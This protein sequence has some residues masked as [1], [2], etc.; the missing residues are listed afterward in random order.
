M[1]TKEVGVAT[2]KDGPLIDLEGHLR[3]ELGNHVRD[4]RVLVSR[5][6]GFA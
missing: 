1:D 2:A 5:A 6:R 3:K 4:L